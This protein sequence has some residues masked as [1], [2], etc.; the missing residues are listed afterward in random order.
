MVDRVRANSPGPTTIERAR[1]IPRGLGLRRLGRNIVAT[2]A[3]QFA[4]TIVGLGTAMVVA[5]LLGPDGNG[6][7]VLAILLPSL[8]GNLLQFGVGAAIVYYVGTG[9]VSVAQARSTALR[10]WLAISVVGCGIGWGAVT[11]WTEK[12]GGVPRSILAAGVA[13]F[14]IILLQ[15]Y[16]LTLLQARQDFRRYNLAHL[17]GPV[18][19]L[20]LMMVLVWL[21]ELGVP[22]ALLAYGLGYGCALVITW[23]GVRHHL[24]DAREETATAGFIRRA[25]SYGWKAHLGNILT[26][27]NYRADLFIVGS[28]LGAAPTGIYVIAVQMSEKLWTLSQAVST[29]IFPR[30]AELHRDEDAR[31]VLTPLIARAVLV[32]TVAAAL[33]LAAASGPLITL[34]FGEQYGEARGALLLLLPGIVLLSVSRVL[35]N[36][37]AARGRPDINM[38]TA[39]VTVVLNVAGNILLVPRMG[40]AGAAIATSA[41]YAVTTVA[42]MYFY[43]RLSGNRWWELVLFS[44]GDWDMTRHAFTDLLRK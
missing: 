24:K 20:P 34:L 44:A 17:A 14:P 3:R 31:R 23:H 40:I 8:L 15:S 32:V 28:L 33:L 1:G 27:L 13:T 9:S 10:L 16:L 43:G 30:L 29:V 37:I 12:F 7:Y 35:S 41:S 6:Q 21:A 4:A 18:A 26:F 38:Y 39:A 36:D 22:G 25:L 11:L 2:L 5:R 42:K 19:T